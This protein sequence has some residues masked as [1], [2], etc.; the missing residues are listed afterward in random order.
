MK[1]YISLIQFRNIEK[2]F[3]LSKDK[4][5][6]CK[7]CLHVSIFLGLTQSKTILSS[8]EKKKIFNRGIS[9]ETEDNNNIVQE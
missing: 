9:S 7:F 8:Y 4:M 2:S 3:L 6:F 1:C 5:L